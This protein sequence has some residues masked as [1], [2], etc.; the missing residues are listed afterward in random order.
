MAADR[1]NLKRLGETELQSLE[2]LLPTKTY[3]KNQPLFETGALGDEIFVVRSGRVK[4]F[5][6]LADGRE[7]V[8]EEASAGD[9]FGEVAALLEGTRN[10]SAVALEETTVLLIERQRLESVLAHTPEV[11][12]VLVHNMARR[13]RRSSEQIRFLQASRTVAQA[14]RP[15]SRVPEYIGSPW[16]LLT[17]ALILIVWS[18]RPAGFDSNGNHLGLVLA[19]TQIVV[20]VLVL[21]SQNLTAAYEE[22]I[23]MREREANLVAEAEISALHRKFDEQRNDLEIQLSA[24]ER[25]LS[26]LR[27]SLDEKGKSRSN[28]I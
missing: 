26:A 9:F 19:V 3:G 25:Q 16:F 17:L 1:D 23:D 7:Y 15:V 14:K 21:R 2:E 20:A 6:R 5:Q 18:F 27:E 28:R 4:L 8:F 12:A 13:L 22:Q 11:G 24:M 10:A